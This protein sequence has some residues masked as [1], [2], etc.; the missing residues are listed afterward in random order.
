MK[1]GT[2]L[3]VDTKLPFQEY[4]QNL[5]K[6]ARKDYKY[7]IK[8]N[9][10]LRYGLV[11][12]RPQDVDK[13]MQIW[14]QQI[15]HGNEEVRWGFDIGHVKNLHEQGV[16]RVFEARSNEAIAMHFVEQHGEYIEAHP[17]MYDK[18]YNT[19]YLAKYMW[20]NLIKWCTENEIKWLDLGSGDR[21]TWRQLLENREKYQRIKYKWLYIAEAVKL[22]PALQPHYMRYEENGTKGI[23]EVDIATGQTI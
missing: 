16:L 6:H 7:V 1:L 14:S 17:P 3:I 11:E 8:H 4:I 10:D 23:C 9:Q 2:P 18:K 13:F 12:F 21:G 20:F 19:R 5:S 15:I 22:Q